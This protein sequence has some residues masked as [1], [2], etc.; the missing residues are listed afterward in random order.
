MRNY[1]RFI[2]GEEIEGCE[3]WR[4]HAIDTA[5][6]LLEAQVR[7]REEAQSEAQVQMLRQD[8]FQAG[9]ADGVIQGRAQAQAEL[10][11]QMADFLA[12]QAQTS[13]QRLGE[14][15][16]AAQSELAKSKQVVAEGV[17][18]LACELARQVLRQELSVNPNVMLPVIRE[19]IEL[20][21]IE[22]Q[23]AVV[24]MHPTDLDVLQAPLTGEFSGISLALRADLNLEPGGCVVESAGMVVDATLQ[25][26]WQRAVATLGLASAWEVP[27]E[28]S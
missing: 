3:Q 15:F 4:F 9:F 5:A 11:Q 1:S 25:K 7:A 18:E 28:P 10:Q 2:P 26:R 12:N 23:S 14:I 6:Q 17:L 16:S 27:S 13:A 24:R 22:H 19:A 21:G 20:L 8:S